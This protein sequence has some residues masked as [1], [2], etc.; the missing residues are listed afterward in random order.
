MREVT[1]SVQELG[2]KNGV[3]CMGMPSQGNDAWNSMIF[4]RV[5]RPAS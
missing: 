3:L 2:D 4:L 5:E 1:G